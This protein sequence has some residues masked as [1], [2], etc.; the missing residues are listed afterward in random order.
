MRLLVL[1][2]LITLSTAS[3]FGGTI[4]VDEF[5][6]LFINGIR[7]P[8]GVKG[9]DPGPGGLANVLIYTLPFAGVQGDV[10]PSEVNP[11]LCAPLCDVVRFNGN[12]TLIFYSDNIDGF[13][14]PADTTGPPT[15]FYTNRVN[16]IEVGPEGNNSAIYTPTANQPGF[17]ALFAPTF[18]LISDSPVPEPSTWFLT[19]GGTALLLLAYVKK[20]G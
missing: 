8:N 19:V 11:E 6:N 1:P 5:G 16:I 18:T 7:G 12:G 17:D 10:F 2:F 14:S 15:I 20:R 13:D 4:S 9:T 3:G